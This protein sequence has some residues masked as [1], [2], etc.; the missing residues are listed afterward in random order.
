MGEL[1]DYLAG[2]HLISGPFKNPGVTESYKTNLTIPPTFR[3]VFLAEEHDK[4]DRT[5]K[6]LVEWTT[7]GF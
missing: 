3:P 2:S 4:C 5:I 6:I 1:G 7:G